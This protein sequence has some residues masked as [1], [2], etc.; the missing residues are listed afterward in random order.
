VRLVPALFPRILGVALLAAMIV[1]PHEA[2]AQG[3]VAEHRYEQGG[4]V[5]DIVIHAGE[6]ALSDS[7]IMAWVEQSADAVSLY[8]GRLPIGHARIEVETVAGRGVRGGQT[9]AGD[10][11]TIRVRVGRESQA[12]DLM[13]RDWVMVHEMIH[14]GIPRVGWRHNWFQE[15][16]AV[17]VES[18]ARVAAGDLP[19]EQIWAD[20]L[21]DMP[22]G[23]PAAGDE[24]LD[25]THS[26]GRTYWGGALYFLLAD[27]RIRQET[28]GRY[29]LREALRGIN[30]TG[31]Y[32]RS[33]PL[34][35]ILAAG[36]A[37][38]GTAVLGDLYTEMKNRPYAPDL[39]SLWKEL[40][41]ALVDGTIR[42]DDEAPLAS[43]RRNLT[44]PPH[45]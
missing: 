20:F 18:I 45:I 15:G 6:M 33:V 40:G 3:S 12:I 17:Y 19:P 39:E 44:E 10:V 42:F 9:R 1:L 25:N 36:D 5:L 14:L 38:T 21:R 27:I 16:A 30:E 2:E 28:A 22:K 4:R 24:G 23:L 34:D 7:E 13:R 43:L 29:G 32:S 41:V 31:D 26:W 35:A 8:F 37:A 11:V